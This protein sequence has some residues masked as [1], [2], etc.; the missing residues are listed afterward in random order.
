MRI[1]REPGRSECPAAVT[2]NDIHSL[3][4]ALGT[5]MG[6][7]GPDESIQETKYCGTGKIL[8]IGQRGKYQVSSIKYQESRTRCWQVYSIHCIDKTAEKIIISCI[9]CIN[10]AQKI[11]LVSSIDFARNHPKKP[12]ANTPAIPPGFPQ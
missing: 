1:Y 10:Q 5:Q 3:F 6:K 9:K 7:P 2:L 8:A 4:L 11:P 12:A